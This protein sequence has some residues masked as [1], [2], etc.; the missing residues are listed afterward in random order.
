MFANHARE[1]LDLVVVIRGGVD[2][3]EAVST[4]VDVTADEKDLFECMDRID[5]F[6]GDELRISVSGRDLFST[7]GVAPMSS[8]GRSM[9]GWRGLSSMGGTL[10]M[11]E[12]RVDIRLVDST[13]LRK[14]ALDK[15]VPLPVEPTEPRLIANGLGCW[16]VNTSV[17][18]WSASA[19][20]TLPVSLGAVKGSA[21]LSSGRKG[22]SMLDRTS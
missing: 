5:D 22:S 21:P 2:L 7:L 15:I 4:R 14:R 12:E 18:N 9:G 17:S 20:Y 8:E 11:S 16:T 3:W 1:N 10:G 13:E 6:E 19:L